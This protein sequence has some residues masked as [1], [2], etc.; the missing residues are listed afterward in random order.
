M[1]QPTAIDDGDE[2]GNDIQRG[3]H[4]S[5][6]KQVFQERMKLFCQQKHGICLNSIAFWREIF[7]KVNL[8]RE[9][10]VCQEGAGHFFGCIFPGLDDKDILGL[11]VSL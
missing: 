9:K 10:H 7:S 8:P 4:K 11:W 3:E 2:D 6:L 1:K 5:V